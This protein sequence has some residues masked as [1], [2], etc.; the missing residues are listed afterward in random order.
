[1]LTAM[2]IGKLISTIC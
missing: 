1:M 2:E